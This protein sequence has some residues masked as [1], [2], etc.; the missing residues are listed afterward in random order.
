MRNRSALLAV[1]AVA[2]M[3]GACVDADV[4][5]DD[6]PEAAPTATGGIIEGDQLD[7]TCAEVSAPEGAPAGVTTM[8]NFF[9]PP[10]VAVSSEQ[11]VAVTNA[12]NL[13]HNFTIQGTEI[14]EDVEPGED[15]DTEEL[16][17]HGVSAGTY[18]FFCRFHEDEGMVGTIVVE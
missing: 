16:G 1:V 14:S 10:C 18:R 2:L 4:G 3:A 6:G 7:E 15:E 5:D 8:D 11:S 13:D 9:E 17:D 12:G